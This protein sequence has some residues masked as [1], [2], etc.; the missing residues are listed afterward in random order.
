MTMLPAAEV[1][2][3]DEFRE[4]LKNDSMKNALSAGVIQIDAVGVPILVL[5]RDFI[6]ACFNRAAADALNL[7]ATDIG[8]SAGAISILSG[9]HDLPTWC[10]DVISTNVPTQHD[11]RIADK[12][13]IVRI[14]AHTSGP[15]SGSV[16]TFTNVTAFRSSID[17]A[18]YEREYAKTILNTV[19]DPLVVLSAE[20]SVLTANRAFYSLLRASREAIHGVP[21]NAL[22]NG[23]LD[24]ARLATQLKDMLAEDGPAFQSFEVD[25]DWPEIGRRTMSLYA[26]PLVLPGHSGGMALLSF[27]DVTE[28]KL[29]EK[30]QRLL[31]QEVDHRAKNLLALVQATVHFS[32]ADTSTGIKAA[33]EGR[34][35]ALSNV[36]TLLANSRWA[37]A[38]LHTLVMDE[39]K[40]YYSRDKSRASVDGPNLTLK[41]QTAQ[42][43]A[44]VLHELTTNAVKYG[45]LSVPTGCVR[46]EWSLDPN[47]K[48]VLRWIEMGGPTVTPPTRQ[49]FGTRVLDRAVSVQL[50]GKSR[51]DWQKNGL[52]C[53][54]EVEAADL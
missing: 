32:A 37:G 38:N 9:L 22:S 26:C 44:M 42:L 54:I 25:C 39:L 48:F 27:H 7:V 5:G 12:W 8:R 46:V 52:A 21:L 18:I 34:I 4:A 31:A 41:P 24:F 10:A 1:G 50:H 15:V 23:I 6:V 35:Q 45:A 33:I 19:P 47:G 30:A 29:A 3:G 49:G 17:Q 28:L 43:M 2:D 11:V 14:A 13:F 40:P 20:L 16:L 36:H 53:E 51:F